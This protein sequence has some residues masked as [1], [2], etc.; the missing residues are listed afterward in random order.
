MTESAGKIVTYQDLHTI[1]ENMIGNKSEIQ[2]RL[3]E[4]VRDSEFYYCQ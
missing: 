4:E 2:G 1:P 3:H